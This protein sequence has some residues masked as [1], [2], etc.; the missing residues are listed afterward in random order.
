MR[1]FF[2]LLLLPLAAAQIPK[3]LLKA[4]DGN[5]PALVNIALKSFGKVNAR[6]QDG[7][8]PLLYAVRNGKHKA[9]KALI[10]G[11]ADTNVADEKG[12][13][14]MHLAAAGGFD[15]VMQILLPAKVEPNSLHEPD[16]MRPIHRAVLSGNTDA[17][18]T[19][20]NAEVSAEQP[21]ADGKTPLELAEEVSD[22]SPGP[23]IPSPRRAM[24][25]L[26][27]KYTQPKDEV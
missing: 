17:V 20:I 21:T 1:A 4:L 7:D 15:R 18:K 26:L 2:L 8:T 11:K 22:E 25:D 16:G 13:T 14:V 10:T 24:M 23:R 19:L 3:E 9:V 6:Q 5:N 27:K 12:L